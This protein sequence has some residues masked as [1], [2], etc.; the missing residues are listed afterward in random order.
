VHGRKWEVWFR[1]PEH[2]AM[3]VPARKVTGGPDWMD[4]ELWD[5]QA[6]ADRP[7]CR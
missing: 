3:N 4:S 2:E 7:G 6:K 1:Y 5:I